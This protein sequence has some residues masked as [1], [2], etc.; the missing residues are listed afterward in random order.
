M[1]NVPGAAPI[2]F[3]VHTVLLALR[4]WWKIIVPIALLFAGAAGAGVYLLHTPSYT[5][6][7]WLLIKEKQVILHR[8]AHADSARFIQNQIEIIRSPR[9]LGPLAS[10]PA[11]LSTPELDD[12]QDVTFGLAKRISIK[13][14]G[15]SDI[16]VVSFSSQSPEK[17][18]LI[19]REVVDNYLAFNTRLESEQDSQ[20]IRLLEDQ[21][22]ARFEEMNQLR[23]NV[24]ALSVDLTGVDPF[25]DRKDDS[26]SSPSPL[27]SL[28]AE[29]VRLE[30]DMDIL[31]ARMK[32][33]EERQGNKKYQPSELEIKRIVEAQPS[34]VAIRDRLD[35]LKKKEIDFRSTGKQLANNAAYKQ[36]KTDIANEEKRLETQKTTLTKE[37]RESLLRNDA[38][39][40]E[41][42]LT[43][44]KEEYEIGN[45][46][47]RILKEKFER[48]MGSAKE[49]AGTSL[50]L[51]FRKSKLEQVTK[52]HDEISA[53]ILNITT[54]QKAPAR[55]EL[56]KEPARP[57]QPD[58]L[59]PWKKIGMV[60]AAGFCVPI[61]LVIAWEHL[62]RRVSSR[63]QLETNQ[64]LVVGEVTSLPSRKRK[65]N[66][67]PGA[68]RDVM[69][70]EESVDSLRTYL[71]LFE[72]LRGLRVLAVTSAISRE[73]KTSLAAQLAAS[74][75]RATG[76]PT[77]LI[78]GDM[79]S[80]DMH[81]IFGLELSPGLAEVLQ[82]ECQLEEAIE[83]SFSDKLHILT[84]GRLRTSPHRLLGKDEFPLLLEQLSG[85][86]RHI[87]VDTPPIL[88]ASEALVMARASDAAVLCMRRDYSRVDQ[89]QEAFSRMSSAGVKVAGAVLNGIPIKH[90]SYKYGTYVYGGLPEAVA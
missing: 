66:G 87:I 85:T 79:R 37:I 27:S 30:V 58:E 31:T 44:M 53:R 42:L 71:S 16:Y 36:L 90:Y 68:D 51:E 21:R 15:Q 63:Q 40:R 19:V 57:V 70:F 32:A 48:G 74:I 12:L 22:A 4:C 20:I 86:Y 9:L 10:K 80:P 6:D 61:A 33:E 73:G 34:C 52:I 46:R 55:V 24:R 78:D 43:Q 56:F 83:T 65:T 64:M 82:G 89:A 45:T 28:Q 76:Q 39:G 5:A 75:A 59:V 77:L 3:N 11:I 72:P 54:E 8:D 7:A 2:Q 1:Q 41:Q 47:L 88:P 14:R 69:L 84:A 13:P 50:E 81:E 38:T 25:R 60:A 62:F 18:E 17:A 23:E 67:K 26:K 35:L 29:I 49:Y